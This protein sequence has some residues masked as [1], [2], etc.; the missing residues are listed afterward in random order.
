MKNRKIVI[1]IILVLSF[2][3]FT[4]GCMDK[5]SEKVGS[6][7]GEKIIEKKL[8][9]DVKVDTSNN[10][11]SIESKDGSYEMGESLD[12]PKDKMDP[13]PVP[14][15]KVISVSSNNE[16]GATDVMMH[17]PNKRMS[18]DYLEKVK[19]LG[20]V[21]G[22]VTD[23]EGFYTYIGHK[24]E[25]NSQISLSSQGLDNDVTL[26]MITFKKD[27]DDTKAF[28]KTL[29]EG[30]PELDLAAIDMNSDLDWP[31]DKMG[32]I[33]ELKGKIETT[34]ITNENVYV[35]LDYVQKSDL[36]DF[37]EK[38]KKLGFTEN[39]YSSISRDNISY[40][41]LN[42]EGYGISILWYN[43][44]VNLNYTFP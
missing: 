12:W 38:V 28:F 20:F 3:L 43:F 33:P 22:F 10:T 23:S 7:I 4:T 19:K 1:L 2:S 34:N 30:E 39:Y 24:E 27:N 8:G 40:A 18:I 31:K 15:A 41:A 44:E 6:K 11:M 26:L 21:E 5:V 9:D 32:N 14:E 29:A 16:S 36:L 37:I 25:D 35:G 42:E 13:L 17:F